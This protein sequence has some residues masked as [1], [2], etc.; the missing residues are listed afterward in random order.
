MPR[1][2]I[3][4]HDPPRGKHYDFM[5]EFGDVLKTWSLPNPPVV[6]FEQHA[7]ILPDHRIAYLDYEGPISN[8]RGTVKPWDKGTYRLIE[9]TEEKILVE[10]AGEKVH[11]RAKLVTAETPGQWKL[12]WFS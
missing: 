1:F 9:Q 3:L 5:L 8:N 6:G 10:L 2:V 12:C 7:E 11:G 4:E